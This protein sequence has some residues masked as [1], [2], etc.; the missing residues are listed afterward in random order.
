[1]KRFRKVYVEISNICNLKC[2]FCP[3]TKR[4]KRAMTEDEFSA[5]LP[6]LQPFTDFLYFH[7]MG[8][9]LC[10]PKLY[11]FIELAS[12]FGFKVILTTNGTGLAAHQ[13]QLCNATG[14]HK[15]NISLH[16]FEANDLAMPFDTYL[17]NCLAFGKA[18]EGKILVCYRLWNNGGADSQND[19]ILSQMHRYFPESW[20]KERG[21]IR[22]GQRVYLEHG[23]KFDWPDLNAPKCGNKVF[24]Y[25][26]RD[27]IGILCDGTVV[28]CCLD[29]EGDIALGNIFTQELEEIITSDRVK[30]IYDGFTTGNAPEELCRRCGYATRFQK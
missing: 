30:A 15:V 20:V 10:H 26:M 27:H 24:C 7:L 13:Q 6:K 17:S 29:H 1:M 22:I 14:L 21:G 23:D 9:P 2:S 12:E 5:L 18:A 11:R 4:Q 25:G 16:A 28:P 19:A 3:G 8:E